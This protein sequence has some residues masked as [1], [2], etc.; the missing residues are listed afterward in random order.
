MLSW[1][2]I[3]LTL[4]ILPDEGRV[5]ST[6]VGRFRRK[7]RTWK[8]PRPWLVLNSSRSKYLRKFG[9]VHCTKIRNFG[10]GS[11]ASMAQW[12]DLGLLTERFWVRTSPAETRRRKYNKQNLQKQWA[13][14][15]GVRTQSNT[16]GIAVR[17]NVQSRDTL[18]GGVFEKYIL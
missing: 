4:T 7:L 10:P 5:L 9:H 6:G 1:V 8:F 18:I 3:E 11:T 2:E 12:L 14:R 15:P 17:D 13:K 16:W